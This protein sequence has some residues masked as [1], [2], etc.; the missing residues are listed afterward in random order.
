MDSSSSGEVTNLLQAV[1]AGQAGATD[2]LL[3]VV[4]SELRRIAAAK[5]GQRG[6][7][8]ELCPTELVSEAYL[9]LLGK[10]V[11]P[12]WEDRKHFYRTAALVVRNI[13]V[14]QAKRRGAKVHGGKA[15]HIEITD[16]VPGK[17]SGSLDM[18]ALDDALTEL[19]QIRPP[20]AEVFGL[21]YF[22]GLTH[23]EVALS[24]DLPVS[25]V[26]RHWDFARGHL[27]RRLYGDESAN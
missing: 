24:M 6:G 15:R 11:V 9:R 21:E 22:A 1:R 17:H 13:L 23:D 7:S 12:E 3:R 19:E 5:L 26:R 10:E 20:A 18:V 14:D 25:A 16:Q 27:A 4:Y 8:D 2:Q